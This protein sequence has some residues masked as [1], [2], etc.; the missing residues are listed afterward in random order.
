MGLGGTTVQM[1]LIVAITLMATA[2][3]VSGL[4]KGIKSLSEGNLILAAVLLAA[5]FLLG[6]TWHLLDSLVQNIGTYLA[7]LLPF[8]FYTEAYRS[9]GEGSW[10][11]GWTIF[12]WA[13]WIAWSPFV[14]M[15]IARISRGRT[16]REFVLG[17]LLVPTTV[18][19]I[20]LTIFGNTALDFQSTGTEIL[21]ANPDDRNVATAMF[22]MLRELP[23]SIILS[24]M[25]IIVVVTF[26]VTSSDSGSLVIDTITGGGHPH[27]PVIQKV[28]W[29]LLEGA[30][31]AV[32]LFAGGL[33][34]LQTASITTGLPFAVVLLIMTYCL[35]KALH[36]EHK[37]S[38]QPVKDTSP[39]HSPEVVGE[40]TW[41]E[42]HPKA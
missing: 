28:F 7:R 25:A 11:H 8:S 24:V 39:T 4:D 1:L 27:P 36:Q 34:A 31:A 12:Y 37:L 6:P 5:V 26:F 21:A 19:F 16:V 15:F 23:I 18:T 3:V 9:P 10:Q 14:G 35:V 42:H 32:L 40:H 2:S 38:V 30:V 17:V 13:W 41:E 22:H 20:W 29:A 33:T